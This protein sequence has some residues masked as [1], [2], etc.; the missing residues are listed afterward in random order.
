M[1]RSHKFRNLVEILFP[2]LKICVSLALIVTLSGCTF[3]EYASY[4]QPSISASSS[5]ASRPLG[6]GVVFITNES[7]MRV[8][9]GSGTYYGILGGPYFLTIFP[10]FLNPFQWL[11]KVDWYEE[12]QWFSL[13]FEPRHLDLSLDLRKIHLELKTGE[14]ITPDL[15]QLWYIYSPRELLKPITENTEPIKIKYGLNPPTSDFSKE[16]KPPLTLGDIFLPPTPAQRPSP[17]YEQVLPPIVTSI[18][19]GFKKK[20]PDTAAR[21]LII[22]GLAKDIVP[23]PIPTVNLTKQSEFRFRSFPSEEPSNL[24]DSPGMFLHGLCIHGENTAIHK[25]EN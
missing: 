7:C 25:K 5:M 3:L 23:L 8:S 16:I 11:R 1:L 24:R 13:E 6:D 14:K 22:N 20:T 21:R 9:E 4:H 19:L 10:T 18:W 12:R 15:Y 2:A 17:F